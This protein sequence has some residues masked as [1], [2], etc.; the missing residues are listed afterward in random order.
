MAENTPAGQNIGD[1]VS[2][3]DDDGNSL[4]YTLGGTDAT[5]FDID[6]TSGQLQTKAS[7]DFETKDSYS[8]TVSVS[9][10]KDA[11]AVPTPRRMTPSP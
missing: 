11:A 1:P 6:I 5:S 7:L 10:G 9:D 4:T 2:A 3:A 8:V